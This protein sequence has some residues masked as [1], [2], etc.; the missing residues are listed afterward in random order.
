MYIQ[1]FSRNCLYTQECTKKLMERVN[2]EKLL[3]SDT[4]CNQKRKHVNSWNQVGFMEKFSETAR[5]LDQ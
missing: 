3:N 4:N 1:K 5:K 2:I